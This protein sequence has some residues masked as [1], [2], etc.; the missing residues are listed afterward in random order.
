MVHEVFQLSKF[1]SG[2]TWAGDS[3]D[4][5][6]QTFVSWLSRKVSKESSQVARRH[7]GKSRP[8]SPGC[9]EWSLKNRVWQGLPDDTPANL[10]F[11][12]K[13]VQESLQ[14]QQVESGKGCKTTSLPI[15]TFVSR[16]S[17]KVSNSNRS[18]L[19]IVARR[20]SCRHGGSKLQH[21]R[22]LSLFHFCYYS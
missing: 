6:Q 22:I 15:Q 20:P 18:S 1:E 10:D 13:T 14:L 7:S 9:L 19:A 4:Y 3:P 12:F 16:L 21:G 17:K 5:L 2:N 11:C 8:L